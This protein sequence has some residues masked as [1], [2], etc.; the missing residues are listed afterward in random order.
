MRY[1]GDSTSFRVSWVFALESGASYTEA[2]ANSME[3]Y[4]EQRDGGYYIAGT[5]TALDSINLAFKDGESPE[6]ILRSF[7]LAGPLVG[8]YGA[9]TFYLENKKAIETY[10]KDQDR[11]WT[12]VRT[13]ETESP[14]G[15]S[16]R[17]R[18]ARA[19]AAPWQ[20]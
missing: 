14:E 17:L 1:G 16:A 11:L 9:I 7:P 4:V 3:S 13:K 18:E 2:E 8:V 6:T 19:H 12:E 5:R 15:L 10:L 20:A